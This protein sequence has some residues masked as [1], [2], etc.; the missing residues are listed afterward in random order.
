MKDDE[1]ATL[2]IFHLKIT[3]EALFLEKA[4]KG[5]VYGM[6]TNLGE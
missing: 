6:T 2:V 4:T 5:P 3:E 1:L